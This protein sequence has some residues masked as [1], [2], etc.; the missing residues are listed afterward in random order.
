MNLD[1]LTNPIVRAAV[2]AL[3]AGDR[4]AW[5]ALFTP[6]AHLTDDGNSRG[7]VEWSD[8]EL[9]GKGKGRITA[10]DRTEENGLLLYA[11]F[12]SEQWGSFSTFFRFTLEGDKIAQLD[13]G[14]VN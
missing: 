1:S 2:T 5:L 12:H 7:V 13:V 9:F 14:Q 11:Q 4:A 8:S 10:I 6:N 3:N